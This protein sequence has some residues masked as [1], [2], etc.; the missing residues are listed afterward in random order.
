MLTRLT[1]REQVQ[2]IYEE[3]HQEDN[4]YWW[5]EGAYPSYGKFEDWLRNCDDDP[6]GLFIN[7][8]KMTNGN[9][10][11]LG[12]SRFSRSDLL[13]G[14]SYLTVWVLPSLRRRR[15]LTPYGLIASAEAINFAFQNF[16]LRKIYQNIV[17][18]NSASLRP[19]QKVCQIEGALKD[20]YFFNGDYRDLITL[21]ISRAD[22]VDFYR[23]YKQKVE[24]YF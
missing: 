4:W 16:P 21:S 13:H 1:M 5:I 19:I 22:W 9:Y 11:L 6:I 20:H 15:G 12:F 3:I 23:R 8:F 2:A 14:F 17:E 10:R 7:S 18:G 24:T